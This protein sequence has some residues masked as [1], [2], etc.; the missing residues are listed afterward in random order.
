MAIGR[1]IVLSDDCEGDQDSMNV[2]L[3]RSLM[4][5]ALASRRITARQLRSILSRIHR[6]V[7]EE[8]DEN[9]RD[10]RDRFRMQI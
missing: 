3:K 6:N 7:T 2:L 8:R 1:A 10:F 5:R 4:T 9:F